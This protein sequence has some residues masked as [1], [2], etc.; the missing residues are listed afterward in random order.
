MS[1]LLD[2]VLA[3]AVG[4]CLEP[5]LLESHTLGRLTTAAQQPA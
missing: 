4:R 1:H 5:S 2:E 3:A